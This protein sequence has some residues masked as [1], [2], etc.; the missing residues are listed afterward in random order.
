MK[1]YGI[2]QTNHG[3]DHVFVYTEEQI[4]SEFEYYGLDIADLPTKPGEC[5]EELPCFPIRGSNCSDPRI[6][7]LET[8]E[9][10]IAFLKQD[11]E[12]PD[13]E[14]P[15]LVAIAEYYWGIDRG[16][17]GNGY[18]AELLSEAGEDIGKVEKH[19]MRF[20]E[21]S[22]GRI[23][24]V[25]GITRRD[26]YEEPYEYM[27]ESDVLHI[28]D[29]C[30]LLKNTDAIEFDEEGNFSIEKLIPETDNIPKQD[31]TLSIHKTD[32]GYNWKLT[33]K[34]YPPV[35]ARANIYEFTADDWESDMED[36]AEF[37]KELV[38]DKI[39]EKDSINISEEKED[40]EI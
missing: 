24:E 40:M 2:I 11:A 4:K 1:Y 28:A 6:W 33:Y 26:F 36:S 39:R 29:I 22:T 21:S 12:G 23:C 18:A 14:D 31:K 9:D 20:V 3:A 8:K 19:A 5:A 25:L 13:Y 38:Q 10:A 17:W 37:L 35:S 30:D 7:L 16:D 34:V 32:D 27:R 15:P